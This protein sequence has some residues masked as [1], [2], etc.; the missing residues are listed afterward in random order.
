MRQTNRQRPRPSLSLLPFSL[1][2]LSFFLAA[3]GP[4][5]LGR[6]L[7]DKIVPPQ[8]PAATPPDAT[9]AE[10]PVPRGGFD[11][12]FAAM[13]SRTPVIMWHDIIARRGRGS[14]WF[15]CTTEEFK[16]GLDTIAERGYTPVSVADLHEHLTTGKSLPAKAVVLTFDDNYQ[17]FYDRAYPL[18]KARGWPAVQFVHTGFVGDKKGAHPKM[19]WEE[20]KKL[21]KDPLITIGSHTV[22]HPDL[23]EIDSSRQVEELTKS[24][25]DLEEHL[26]IKVDTFAYPEGKN[27]AIVQGEARD[28]GYTLAFSI[29]NMPA[30][31]SPNILCVGRWVH[32][33]LEKA[34]DECERQTR[35]GADA[36]AQVPLKP[37]PVK[38]V[39]TGEGAERLVMLQG[40]APESVVSATRESVGDMVKRTGAAGG[41]NGTF[42]ALAA[43]N[44]TDNQLIGPSMVHGQALLPATHPEIWPKLRGRPL[45]VWGPT[46]L[47]IVPYNP[48]R[49][50]DPAAYTDLMPDATDAFL[51]GAWL[52]H[53]GQA[54]DKESLTTFASKDIEDPRRRAAFGVDAQGQPVCACTRD[55]VSSSKFA[56]MLAAAGLR[57]AVLLD[58][59]FSTSLVLGT[60]VLASGHS[61]ADQPSRPVPHA[62]VLMGETDPASQTA[63]DK[64]KLASTDVPAPLPDD[65]TPK[66][67]RRRHRKKR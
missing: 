59:G 54:R 67:H 1:L 42:F 21:S 33:R 29:D 7:A 51:A 25:G 57:E 38:Y 63:A 39:D 24:K 20:L 41:I 60:D 30:E 17:G 46:G 26:G 49:G 6:Q 50:N 35:G 32:T 62:V 37:G 14:V 40:G 15:D 8:T 53:D 55:S 19:T 48:D 13:G 9:E 52:V 11:I 34:L 64:A 3:C 66:P 23:P 4:N 16:K 27:D 10:K 12:G 5:S 56:R 36:V 58:S 31:A 18:L 44:A 61:T 2:P 45:L 22:T 28:A 43:I 65:A 47:A